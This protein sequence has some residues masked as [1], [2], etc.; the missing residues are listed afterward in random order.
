MAIETLFY[1]KE[2]EEGLDLVE[3]EGRG[4]FSAPALKKGLL[5]LR[6]LVD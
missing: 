4:V 5:G 2:L 1:R 6:W 3:R